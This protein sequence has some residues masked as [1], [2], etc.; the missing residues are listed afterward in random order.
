MGGGGKGGEGSGADRDRVNAKRCARAGGRGEPEREGDREKYRIEGDGARDRE[1]GKTT[2]VA[3]VLPPHSPNVRPFVRQ[4]ARRT[5]ARP[6][7]RISV[8]VG[9]FRVFV[10][11]STGS[12]RVRRERPGASC[13]RY[14]YA[15]DDD[16]HCALID[17][18][19]P[20]PVRAG[21]YIV[22]DTHGVYR[23]YA[24]SRGRV[25]FFRECS[26]PFSALRSNL[27]DSTRRRESER[28]IGR[29]FALSLVRSSRGSCAREPW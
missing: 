13:T 24:T 18:P 21:P 15:D 4:P 9:S 23:S 28:P 1:K 14:Y 6:A 8:S 27:V 17:A 20:F 19:L 5:S 25:F 7:A 16:G 10:S 29:R 22:E 3:S 12:R 2:V 11:C 26:R